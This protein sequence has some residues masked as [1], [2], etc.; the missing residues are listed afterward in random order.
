MVRNQYFSVDP[1]MRARMDDRPSYYPP[2]PLNAPLDGDAV[3]IVADSREPAYRPGQWVASDFGWRES[4]IAGPEDIRPLPVPPAS[5]GY[6]AYLGVLGAT[7]LT[8]YLG[9][10]DILK[11]QPGDVVLITSAAGAVGSAAGQMCKAR[12]ARVIGSTSTPEKVRHVISRYRF[13][14]AFDYRAEGT[15]EALARLAPTGINGMLDSVGGEQLEAGIEAMRIGGRIAKCGAIIGYD[16]P[17]PVP[18]PRNMHHF[19][20]KRLLLQGFLV[21]DHHDRVAEFRQ[22]AHAW[23]SGG[24]LISDET[25][26]SGIDSAVR[27]FLQLFEGRN[28][29]KTVVSVADRRS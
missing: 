20:G 4:F 19:F 11:P 14:A 23:L 5:L 29:G 9:V 10:N 17:Y 8:A 16:T 7:G 25:M 2:W 6:S 18:G 24:Q 13:D 12:G 21:S 15:G 28:M 27:A 22:R 3:G 26:A 1:Y